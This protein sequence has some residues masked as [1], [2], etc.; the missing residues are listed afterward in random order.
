MDVARAITKGIER[1][2]PG[3]TEYINSKGKICDAPEGH[4]F[5]LRLYKKFENDKIR[6]EQNLKIK[7]GKQGSIMTCYFYTLCF[8]CMYRFSVWLKVS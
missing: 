4:P 5:V 7:P 3:L 1:L 8:C 2:A 6:K